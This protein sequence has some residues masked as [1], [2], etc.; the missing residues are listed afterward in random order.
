M[1]KLYG[2][3]CSSCCMNYCETF[4]K[5]KIVIII[6]TFFILLLLLFLLN[7]LLHIYDPGTVTYIFP[8]DHVLSNRLSVGPENDSHV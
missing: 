3:T 2:V 8:N 6:I 7:V 1:N 5:T 4:M